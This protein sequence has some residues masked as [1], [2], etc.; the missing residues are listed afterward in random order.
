MLLLHLVDLPRGRLRHCEFLPHCEFLLHFLHPPDALQMSALERL[1]ERLP[2]ERLCVRRRV[3]QPCVPHPL[4]HLLLHPL[5]LSCGLPPLSLV[6]HCVL[7]KDGLLNALLKG[8]LLSY[9]LFS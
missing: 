4:L 1:C 6:L 2:L 9:L 5:Y 7:R 3:Y 8:D